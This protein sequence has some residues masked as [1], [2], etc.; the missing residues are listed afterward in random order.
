MTF[1]QHG[2]SQVA[3]RHSFSLPPDIERNARAVRASRWRRRSARLPFRTSRLGTGESA[4]K[5]LS[6]YLYRGVIGDKMIPESD[7]P[8]IRPYA[9]SRPSEFDSWR[10]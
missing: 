4:L 1:V 7:V 8:V 10:R 2:F 3:T 6:R 5:N 9:S